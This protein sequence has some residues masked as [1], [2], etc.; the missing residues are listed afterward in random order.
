MALQSFQFSSES[1]LPTIA[2]ALFLLFCVYILVISKD[3]RHM[4]N[5]WLF[6]A[7]LSLLFLLF[8]VQAIVSAG[9]L[10]FWVEHTRNLWGNQIW[11]DLLLGI[12]IGWYLVVP[13][14]KALNMRLSIWL[15]LIV[16]TGSIGFLA[17]ISRLLYLRERAEN[18]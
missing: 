1:L 15:A 16:C 14:A 12:G 6:P 9:F 13:Q 17:T 7:T 8:S 11:F 18:A 4:K 2:V 3:D 5:S 10:G